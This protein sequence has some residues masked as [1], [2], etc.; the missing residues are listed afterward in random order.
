MKKLSI[1]IIAL[2]TILVCCKKTPEVNIK[3][4]DVEREVLTI[5][6]TTANIQCDYEYIATLKSAKLYYGRIEDNM[7][8]VNMRVV[9]SV[10]YAEITGLESN[11]NYK[12][13]Y[14]FENG[15]N[16]M[17]SGVKTFTTEENPTTVVLPTVITAYV[18]EITSESAVSGGEVISDGGGNVTERGIC[19]SLTNNPTLSN[20]HL[21][22]GNGVGVFSATIDSLAANT[23]YHVRAYAINE[24]GTAYGLDKEFTTLNSGGGGDAPT[25]AINGLFTI[26]ENGDKVYFSQGNLQYKA[27]TNTWRFAEHQWDFVGGT[28]S[29][30]GEVRGTVYENEVKC[31]NNQKS[32]TYDG[33][34]DLF[35]WATSGWDGGWTYYHPYDTDYPSPANCAYYGPDHDLTDMYSNGDWGVYNSI[36]N[37]GNMP[38]LWRTLMNQEWVYVFRERNTS[39]GIR[40]AKATVNNI[41]GIILL[42]DDWIDSVFYL[43]NTNETEASYNNNSLSLTEWS[44]LENAGAVFLPAAGRMYFLDLGMSSIASGS[45][46]GYWSAQFI[47]SIDYMAY[48]IWLSNPLLTWGGRTDTYWG[49]S[50]RLVQDSYK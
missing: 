8:Y 39:S 44:V 2:L 33:W 14:E 23:T 38:N 28:D 46:G 47:N 20:S 26:N 17:Q 4:V 5:G 27:S 43:N 15:F 9:Q 18:T 6:S 24:A 50:V 16:S 35:G 12:Y 34:I 21:A 30:N 42:P 45:F 7:N 31:N 3:Y 25:G 49:Y 22:I 32:A 37:G 11:T 10:L 1:I 29:Y 36:T 40:F 13:Y 48:A 19:W 41:D